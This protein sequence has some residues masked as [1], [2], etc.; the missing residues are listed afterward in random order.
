MPVMS[1]IFTYVDCPAN[2]LNLGWR[3]GAETTRNVLSWAACSA[4]SCAVNGEDVRTGS[5]IMGMLGD[6]HINV[7]Q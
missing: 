5:G 7:S 1:S 3:D 4:V 6:G 2:D